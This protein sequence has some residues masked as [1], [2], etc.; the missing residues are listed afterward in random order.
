MTIVTPTRKDV[1]KDQ[2]TDRRV[3]V[4][5]DAGKAGG[6]DERVGAGGFVIALANNLCRIRHRWFCAELLVMPSRVGR[7]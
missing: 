7:W 1:G 4:Q 3:D 2:M 6:K 5:T